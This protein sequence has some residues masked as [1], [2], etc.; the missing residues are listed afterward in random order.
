MFRLPT[1]KNST[2][3]NEKSTVPALAETLAYSLAASKE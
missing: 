3:I 1:S 2:L